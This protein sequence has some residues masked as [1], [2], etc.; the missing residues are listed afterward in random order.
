MD[1]IHSLSVYQW[2]FALLAAFLI[3]IS[4]AGIRGIDVAQVTIMALIFGSKASTGIVL[5]LLC[6][7]DLLAVNYYHRH[8]QWKYVRILMPWL[9]AGVLLGV[10]VGQDMN[11]AVFRKVMAMIIVLA[12][13]VLLWF[14]YKKEIIIPASGWFGSSMGLISGITTMLGNLAGAF[15]SIYFLALK[16]PKSNFIGTISWL[17]LI[18]N[19]FK[20]PFQIIFWKNVNSTSIKIDLMLVPMVIVGFFIGVQIVKRMTSD[21]YRKMVLVLTLIGCLVMLFK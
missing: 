17:F 21:S 16:V 18:I 13:A 19:L 1:F 4:K 7:A 3:G 6:T 9:I 2:L 14:E 15:S 11:E 12:I 20:V 5:L 10:F 8:A